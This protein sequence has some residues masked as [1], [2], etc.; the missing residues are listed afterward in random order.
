MMF[1]SLS[2]IITVLAMGYLAWPLVR[3]GGGARNYGLALVLVAPVIAL[4]AYQQ[5]GTPRGIGVVGSPQVQSRAEADH[6][7]TGAGQMDEMIA[8]LEQRLQENPADVAGWTLLGRSYKSVGRY[9]QAVSALTRAVQLA[10][11]DALVLVELAEARMFASGNPKVGGD[12]REMLERALLIDPGQQKGLWLLGIAASQDGNDALAVELWERLSAQLDPSSGVATSLNEQ[13]AQARARMGVEAPAEWPGIEIEVTLSSPG[14]EAPPGAVLFVIARNPNAPGPPV[15]VRRIAN[16][17]FP[18]NITLNDRDSMVPQSPVSAAATLQ[19]Q[20]RLSMSGNV[21][22]G[23]GDL[24]SGAV[25]S[26]PALG[27]KVSLTLSGAG[28]SSNPG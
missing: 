8:Q 26:V 27:E 21:I 10:P 3:Q 14:F 5:I 11:D 9:A 22:A 23:P 7:T 2:V 18:V 24:S 19:I 12:V 20:A 25:Q 4:I 1:W 6:A 28:A 16:P 15:G 17:V 13:I